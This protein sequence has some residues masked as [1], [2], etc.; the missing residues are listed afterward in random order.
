MFLSAYHFA[1]DPV[2][3]AASAEAAAAFSQ[4]AE[5]RQAV[6]DAGLPQPQ[7]EPLGE[8]HDVRVRDGVAP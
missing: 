5:F 1:G 7:L 6:A 8:V 3:L 4:S 2:A